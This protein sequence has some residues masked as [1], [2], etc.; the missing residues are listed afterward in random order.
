MIQERSYKKKIDF[1]FL[2]FCNCYCILNK[3]RFLDL[4]AGTQSIQKSL[5]KHVDVTSVDICAKNTPTIVSDIRTWNY[6]R[7]FPRGYFDVI[8]ASPP[9]T[10][11]SIARTVGTRDYI[12]ADSIV[13]RCL[14][15]IQYFR[16]PM[17]FMENPG[18]GGKLHTRPFMCKWNRYKNVCC[19]CRYGYPYRKITNIWT[20]RTK[21]GLK[22]C[23]KTTPCSAF[24]KYG[25]HLCTAQGGSHPQRDL[26]TN[27]SSAYSVPPKLIRQL[28]IIK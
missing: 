7:Q 11:Y 26:G 4:C 23:N 14:E 18:G 16:P 9:C 24:A 8:W 25:R 15:I 1:L 3:M 22:I 28:I 20:N 6:K 12:E 17:W 5:P 27:T 21:L 2:L 10:Q 13:K 19:Y